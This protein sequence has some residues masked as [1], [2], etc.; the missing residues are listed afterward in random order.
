MRLHYVLAVVAILL[1]AGC[2]GF[3]GGTTDNTTQPSVET[4]ASTEETDPGKAEITISAINAPTEIDYNSTLNGSVVFKN[5]GDAAG[6]E[7]YY[8]TV[9][10]TRVVKDSVQLEA[11]ETKSVNIKTELLTLDQDKYDIEVHV[12]GENERTGFTLIHP[13]PYGSENV[14]LYVND[15]AVDRNISSVVESATT[16]WEQNDQRYLG[17]EIEYERTDTESLADQTLV[18]TNV[19][20]CGIHDRTQ[21]RILGCGDLTGPQES[22]PTVQSEVQYNLSDPRMEDTIIHEFGHNHGLN[23]SQ[24]PQYIMSNMSSPVSPNTTNVYFRTVQGQLPSSQRRSMETALDHFAKDRDD[25]NVEHGFRWQ[26]VDSPEKAHFIITYAYDADRCGFDEGGGSCVSDG[27]YYGQPEIVLED[28]DS[29]VTAWHVGANLQYYLYDEPLDE[30][31]GD[32]DR[33]GR[34][35]WPN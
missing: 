11:G 30:F 3:A 1:L 35:D 23:H 19:D 12:G 21:R 10:G 26:A 18:F 15:S 32:T 29:E 4:D 27:A 8:I 2:G 16:Y 6:E 5:T 24:Q 31:D 14:T 28:T 25:L 13:S 34:E 17:Y 20:R 7:D 33:H 22:Y 9:A